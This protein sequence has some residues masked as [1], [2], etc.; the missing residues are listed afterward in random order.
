MK[1]TTVATLGK[2]ARAVK[3][4]GQ[5]LF[6]LI[7]WTW[8]ASVNVVGGLVCLFLYPF[9]KH[10]HFGNALITYVPWNQGG[11]S[12]GLFIFIA[13]DRNKEWT[14]NTRIHEYGHTI[15]CL[16]LGPLYWVVVALPSAIWC[17]FFEGYR[18][19]NNVSYYKL[20]CE[21]WANR[22]GEKWSDIKRRNDK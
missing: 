5:Y 16:L 20:Y 6:F 14:F 11:L 4:A 8:G 13:A 18:R 12:L 21:S 10:E 1:K 2:R 19:R 7:Q 17:N 9:C 3:G 22:W 15:Q